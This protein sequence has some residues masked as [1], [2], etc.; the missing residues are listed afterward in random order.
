MLKVLLRVRALGYEVDNSDPSLLQRAPATASVPD[1]VSMPGSP[2][3]PVGPAAVLSRAS[4]S[5]ETVREAPLV[6]A[7]PAGAAGEPGDVVEL[8]SA[9]GLRPGSPVA[10]SRTVI[11]IPLSR[12][13]VI[14][15]CSMTSS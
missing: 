6:V 7:V 9:E 15:T 10:A 11:I 2:S 3:T 8:E 5:E 14:A 1:Q 13:H 4:L 12:S